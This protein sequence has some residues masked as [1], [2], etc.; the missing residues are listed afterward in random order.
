VILS[1]YVLWVAIFAFYLMEHIKFVGPEAVL[2]SEDARGRF[3][4]RVARVPFL[5]GARQVLLL[6][7]FPS[8]SIFLRGRLA[9][10]DSVSPAERRLESRRIDLLRRKLRLFAEAE[11]VVF[12]FYFV[13][14]PIVTWLQGLVIALLVFA[15]V[16]IGILA[17]FWFGLSRFRP[18]ATEK[19]LCRLCLA[20]E[21]IVVP[22]MIPAFS[23]RLAFAHVVAPE[24]ALLIYPKLDEARRADVLERLKFRIGDLR[25]N[26]EVA[27][28]VATAYLAAIEDG[29]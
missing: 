13:V 17:Y 20:L 1:E 26:S 5:M 10:G 11:F 25:D 18:L 2:V 6:P 19:P 4:L 24:A 15:P 16:Q 27:E 12:A 29:A 22:G 8:T 23:K 14:L 7:P 3:G 9:P 28:P 21:M